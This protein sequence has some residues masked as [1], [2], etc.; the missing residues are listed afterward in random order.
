MLRDFPRERIYIC[1]KVSIGVA[2]RIICN[3]ASINSVL[4]GLRDWSINQ[5]ET[6]ASSSLG[7]IYIAE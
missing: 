1:Q 2:Y 5:N 6:Y 3:L 7:A 4:R